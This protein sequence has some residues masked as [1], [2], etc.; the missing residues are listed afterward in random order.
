M[1]DDRLLNRLRRLGGRNQGGSKS[2]LEKPHARQTSLP[3][4]EDVD[5]PYGPAYLLQKEYPLD[6]LHG[7]RAL[8]DLLGY[9]PALVAEVA[10]QPE[11]ADVSVGELLFLDTETTGL[12]GGAGTLVFLVGLGY[13]V[14]TSFRLR[15]YFLRDPADEASMLWALQ[16]DLESASGFISFNGRVFDIPLLEMRYMIG[17]RRRWALT[18]QPQLDLLHP[19]RRL[20]RRILPDCR[21]STIERLQLGVERS[22]EDVSGSEIPGMYLDYLRT[23]DAGSMERVMYHNEVDIL[24][25]VGLSARILARYEQDNPRELQNA[26]ALAVAR[27]HQDAGRLDQAEAAYQAA[28]QTGD[29]ELQLAAL[30]RY[31][32]HLKRAGKREQAL[33]V[34]AL[35]HRLRPGDPIPCVELAKYY[36]WHAG[37]LAE[38]K[39]WA[40]QAMLSL[41]HWPEGWQRDRAWEAVEHRIKRLVRKLEA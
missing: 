8:S 5:T 24:S 39:R 1:S 12:A 10:G 28:L 11:L 23:G 3:Q 25:L 14:G 13:F 22:E 40:E 19:A 9:S 38:A 35:W 16:E 7:E 36:E 20:W 2:T 41:T 33:D 26:E 18:A 32:G 30:K 21:L 27:W 17:L 15:Q 6:H 31:A 29:L 34:W 37:D 4:G